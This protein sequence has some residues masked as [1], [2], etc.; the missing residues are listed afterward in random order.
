[1]RARWIV[2]GAVAVV[3]LAAAST[4]AIGLSVGRTRAVWRATCAVPA[5]DGTVVEVTLSNMGGPMMHGPMMGGGAVQGGMM[6]LLAAPATVP[7]GRVSFV[8][9]N[10]GSIDHELVI[11][12]VPDGQIVGTR[13]IGGDGT[14]DE[15]GSLGE[16]SNSCS[17]GTGDGIA[18]GS[19]GW[20]TVTLARGR[21]EL[22]CNLPGHY[23]AGMYA[24]LTVQ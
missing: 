15:S 1:M 13:P 17:A 2:V 8:A 14:I 21:Y 18:P 4:L 12:P 19:S 9:T 24:Q 23:A 6:R 5:F 22:V 16:A 3:V 20:V 11:L 7:A 10:V